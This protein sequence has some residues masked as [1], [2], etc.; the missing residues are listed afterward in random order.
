MVRMAQDFNMR[1]PLIDGQGSFG[2]LTSPAPAAMRYTEARLEALSMELLRDIDKNTVSWSKN[3]DDTLDEPDILP[4]RFP[5]LLVNG[6]SGI[7]IGFSMNIPPHNLAETINASIAYIDNPDITT[8]EMMKIIKSP[9]F[10]TGGYIIAGEELRQAYET[11]KGK[12]M[13]RAKI[14][15]EGGDGEKKNIV[16]TEIPYQVNKAR[17]QQKILEVRESK[18]S[19]IPLSAASS[20]IY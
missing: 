12:I 13:I 1:M 7:A 18:I 11:G 16:V 19:V 10:P 3:F 2:S 9:D 17:L 4:G 6:A 14:H 8:R 20:T 15:I 5:N